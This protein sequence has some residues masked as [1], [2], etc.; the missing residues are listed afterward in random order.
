MSI[1]NKLT[2]GIVQRDL[3]Q[4]GHALLTKWEKTGLLEGITND[5]NRRLYVLAYSKT[6]LRSFFVRLPL[7]RLV[8]SKASLL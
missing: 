4:E 1:L 7:W 2:E 5:R 3:R 8:M 6:K